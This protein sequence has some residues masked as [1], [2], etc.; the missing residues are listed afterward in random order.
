[1]CLFCSPHGTDSAAAQSFCR[2]LVVPNPISAVLPVALVRAMSVIQLPIS[3]PQPSGSGAQNCQICFFLSGFHSTAF[4][5]IMRAAEYTF[6]IYFFSSCFLYFSS[7]TS[8]Y[9]TCDAASYHLQPHNYQ[10]YLFLNNFFLFSVFLQFTGSIGSNGGVWCSQCDGKGISTSTQLHR[11]GGHSS[12]PQFVHVMDTT[13][14][15]V[16]FLPF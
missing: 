15:F 7:Q 4:G 1:M 5:S 9:T 11:F 10:L 8:C 13:C 16:F 2:H 6:L 12:D 14:D 3:A